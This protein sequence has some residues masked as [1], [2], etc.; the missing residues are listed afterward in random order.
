[1]AV[2]LGSGGAGRPGLLLLGGVHARE[3]G[4]PD[5]LVFFVQQLQQS[6]AGGTG[7]TLGGKSFSA[8]QIQSIIRGLDLY[9]F[10]Q[11]NPDGRNY[12]LTTDGLWRKNRRP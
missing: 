10:P 8:A 12:S 1:H 9:V 6:F 7:I 5:I 3:W 4:S 11:V 2:K